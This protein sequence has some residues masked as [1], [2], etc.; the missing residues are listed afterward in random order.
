MVYFEKSGGW[1]GRYIPEM[2]LLV[3]GSS[4]DFVGENDVLTPIIYFTEPH[5]YPILFEAIISFRQDVTAETG[6]F[7]LSVV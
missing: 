4:H 2:F 3:L 1:V 7:L 5:L 6:C